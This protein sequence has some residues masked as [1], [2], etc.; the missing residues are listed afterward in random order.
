MMDM[1]SIEDGAAW[2]APPEAA[3]R[4]LPALAA[5]P[6]IAL[7]CQGV[8]PRSRALVRKIH[9][10]LGESIFREQVLFGV[11]HY[12]TR[13]RIRF[14]SQMKPAQQVPGLILIDD[15]P[16]NDSFACLGRHRRD[17]VVIFSGRIETELLPTIKK[18]LPF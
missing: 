4:P 2:P 9:R 15:L 10:V 13:V 3:V 14:S 12:L 11:E 1:R 7:Y 16:E 18:F 8:D 6:D 5:R 17:Q